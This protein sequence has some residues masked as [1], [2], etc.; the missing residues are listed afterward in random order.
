MEVPVRTTRLRVLIGRSFADALRSDDDLEGLAEEPALAGIPVRDLPR[1]LAGMEVSD[2]RRDRILAAVL[3]RYRLR[4]TGPW[5]ALVLEMLAP[6]LTT[7]A[8]NL[9]GPPPYVDEDDLHHQLIVEAL[10]VAATMPVPVPPRRIPVRLRLR[11]ATR[12]EE[13]LAD[14]RCRQAYALD[15]AGRGSRAGRGR[16][17]MLREGSRPL[18]ELPTSA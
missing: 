14:Q 2:E 16:R 15:G 8:A 13:W 17:T 7:V 9:S 10:T 12:V 1:L 18:G 3:R 11:I 5:A 4:P 6:V